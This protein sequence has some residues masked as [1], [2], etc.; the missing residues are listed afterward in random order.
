MI[1]QVKWKGLWK[2][3]VAT[4]IA[5]YFENGIQDTANGKPV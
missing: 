4:N 1:V 3:G 2:I 5:I